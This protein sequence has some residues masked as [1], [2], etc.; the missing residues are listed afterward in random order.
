MKIKDVVKMFDLLRQR[1]YTIEEI[2]EMPI[3]VGNK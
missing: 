2:L 3:V 1:G